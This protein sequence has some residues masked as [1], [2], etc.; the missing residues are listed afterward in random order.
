VDDDDMSRSAMEQAVVSFGHECRA[1]RDGL[2]ALHLHQR[3]RA[4]VILSDWDMPNMD[5]LELCK[6]T[7]VVDSEHQYTYFV[8]VTAFD[9]KEHF[10]HGMQAGADDYLTKPVDLDELQARLVSAGRVVSLYRR[11]AAMNSVLRR[12]SQNSF[13][14]ARVDA[15][16]GVANRL[17]LNEDLEALWARARRYGHRY[18]VVLCDIDWFK[19]YND[20]FG[21]VAGD[22]ALR[23]VAET[24]SDNLRQGDKVYRYGGEEFLVVLPEQS[25][26]DAGR[27][28]E[29]L[30][31]AVEHRRLPTIAGTG[32]VTI[33][34]GVAE[35]SR[36]V[37]DSVTDW[38]ERADAALY[39]A[40][41]NGRNRVEAAHLLSEAQDSRHLPSKVAPP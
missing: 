21:H 17:R 22:A 30:R 1:V 6:R 33:S 4:D 36:L 27:A 29:R 35:F 18:S 28:A 37:D 15:L 19:T 9:R 11:L 41:A 34:S 8:F 3:D 12:D 20:Q 10:L 2:E 5:G 31:R 24:I 13:S 7:R 16:T 23:S 38:L 25:L 40:K 26:A 32:V 14:L 39:R